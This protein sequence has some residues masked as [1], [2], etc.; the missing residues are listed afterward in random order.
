[1]TWEQAVEIAEK[2]SN[3][4]V[5]AQKDLESSEWNYKKAYSAFL[6]QLSASASMTE[7]LS[8]TSSAGSKSYSYGLSASQALFKGMGG[9]YGIQSAYA[10]V[11]YKRASLKSTQ[12]SVYYD[13]RS[14]F[15]DLFYA[16]EN[17]KLLEKIL[18]QRKEN[19][20]L[21]QL[22][23][24]SGKEDKG[25]L[26]TT[27]A[28]QAQAEYDLSSA[29]RGIKLAKLKISQLLSQDVDSADGQIQ[30]EMPGAV[31]FDALL[32]ETPSYVIAEKQL[33]SAE[34]SYKS[35]ISGFLPSVSLGANLSRR[36]SDWPPDQESSSWSLS[37]S[38][39]FFPGGSNVAERAAQ[40]A[41]LD[42]AREDFAKQAKDLR[43]SL[44]QAFEDLNDA[45]ESLE[46]SK[47]S[48]AANEERAK[49]TEVK[50]LNGLA[51]YDEWYRIENSYISAQKNLLNSKKQ[52]LLAE[53][54]WHKSYGGYV[55]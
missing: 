40:S 28:D 13:I 36:G 23:Y 50:Y 10:D 27:R 31:D 1:L 33:E 3:E 44:E 18:K 19:T 38:Y 30:F 32:E 2:N 17:L 45:I 20:G 22:R 9:I 51:I 11:E 25:N 48:L 47:I 42:G 6:P 49:I 52:A 35:T 54:A 14:A 7:T 26:M 55:K 12:A 41:A 21:I 46:V 15:I 53:A 4:L 8:G 34:L 37:L 16:Q 43:Y 24:E 5:S 29:K 39:P